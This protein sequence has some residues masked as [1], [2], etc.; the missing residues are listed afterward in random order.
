MPRLTQAMNRRLKHSPGFTLLELV[1]VMVIVC[2]V[3]AMA[4][5]SLRNFWASRRDDDA[6]TQVLALTQWARSHA[7]ID[8]RIYR[9]TIDSQKSAYRLT[10][11]DYDQ[12]IELGEEFGRL[13][14][15]PDDTRISLTRLDEAAVDYIDF[16]PS[17]RMD[18]ATIRITGIHNADLRIVC[19]SPTEPF[20]LITPGEERT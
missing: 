9:L 10:M 8:G 11:Q 6:A 13:F 17:G 15:M 1:L 2:V 16:F 4:A 19:E 12:F 7:I 14:T 5:P 3:L 18:P 20:R